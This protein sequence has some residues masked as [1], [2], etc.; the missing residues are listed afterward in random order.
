MT[1]LI[2]CLTIMLSPGHLMRVIDGDTW[3]LWSVGVPA[4]ERVRVLGVNAAEIRDTLG[5]AAKAFTEAW[6]NAGPYEM[7]TCKRDSFGRLLAVVTRGTDTLAVRLIE[8]RLG[9]EAP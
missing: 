9:T 7:H 4:E 3:V 1:K 5:P 2:A 6:L 8:A